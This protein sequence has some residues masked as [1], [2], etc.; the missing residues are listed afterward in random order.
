MCAG[1][2]EVI[3]KCPVTFDLL[4]HDP[5]ALWVRQLTSDDLTQKYSIAVDVD[6]RGLRGRAA[7]EVTR[8]KGFGCC[9]DDG[10]FSQRLG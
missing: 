1:D 6:L 9:V 10:T 2:Y 5:E 7:V 4:Q 3:H 8:W